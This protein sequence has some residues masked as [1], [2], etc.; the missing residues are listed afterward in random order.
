[1]ATSHLTSSVKTEKRG[2]DF[3]FSQ[4]CENAAEE[5][6]RLSRDLGADDEGRPTTVT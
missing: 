5:D 3:R 4:S 6:L 1:L 2:V